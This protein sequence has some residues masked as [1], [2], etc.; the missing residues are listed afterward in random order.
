MGMKKKKSFSGESNEF[1]GS[2]VILGSASNLYK[3][4]C[5]Q[6]VRKVRNDS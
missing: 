5:F 3:K 1:Y 2:V 6:V 4:G